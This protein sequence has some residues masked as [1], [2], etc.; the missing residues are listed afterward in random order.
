MENKTDLSSRLA[1]YIV[2]FNDRC[3]QKEHCLRALLTAYN[4]SEHGYLSVVNPLCYPKDEKPCSLYRS[5]KKIRTAWGFTMLYDN[6]PERIA[7]AVR[8]DLEA[9][10]H[11]TPYYRYRNKVLGISPQQQEYIRRVCLRHGWKE[12]PVFDYYTE[13]YDW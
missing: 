6:M 10:F 5:D 2:C 11:H 4:T 1:K 9:H 7:R 3:S 12:E 13:E 8:T